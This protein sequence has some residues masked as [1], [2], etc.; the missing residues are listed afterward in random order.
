MRLKLSLMLAAALVSATPAPVFAQYTLNVRDADIRAF[1][2]D[3]ARITGRTFVIDGRVNG[4]VSVVTDRPLS[5][6]E[7]FEIFLSTLRSNG[8]VAVLTDDRNV[9]SSRSTAPPRSRAGSAAAARRRTSSSPKS[10]ACAIS[11]RSRRLKPC[12]RWSARRGR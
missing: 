7:Y 3:A 2:Q 12:A 6:S 11:T 1:I 5:R 8:L 9:A 4:K 10:F